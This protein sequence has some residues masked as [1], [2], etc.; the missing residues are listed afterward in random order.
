MLLNSVPKD[1]TKKK[2]FWKEQSSCRSQ[3]ILG[4]CKKSNT[5]SLR[6]RVFSVD[7]F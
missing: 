7:D 3:E 6:I 4:R 1:I 2:S 5:A